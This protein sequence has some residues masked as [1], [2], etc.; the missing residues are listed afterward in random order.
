MTADIPP[1]S[2]ALQALAVP[3]RIF[4]HP[5]AVHSLEQAAAERGQQPGQV[6]RS[7]VFRLGAGAY[8]MALVAGPA[9]VSWPNL[10]RHLNQSRLTMASPDEVL[11]VTGY[12]TGAVGPFGL[13]QPLRLLV[14]DSVFL[15]EELS[16]G[17]GERGVT[18][19]LKRDDLLNALGDYERGC[20]TCE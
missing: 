17:S 1:V 10:R 6:V 7:I 3:H 5:G 20:F 12:P 19:I 15:P 18:V 4:R 9:Q 8:A 11:A 14:D 13:P 16:I 2:Q